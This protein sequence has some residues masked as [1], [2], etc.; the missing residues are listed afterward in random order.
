MS[1]SDRAAV[2]VLWQRC[3]EARGRLGVS[4]R[5]CIVGEVLRGYVGP[6]ASLSPLLDGA[7]AT[8]IVLV[9]GLL[10]ALCACCRCVGEECVKAV[11]RGRWSGV[12]S[13]GRAEPCVFAVFV[14]FG[15]NNT[16]GACL[17]V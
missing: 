9:A 3:A 12:C 17:A 1:D 11:V 7:P 4:S 8:F 14:G 16:K 2:S 13:R 10:F 15:D 5:V 6:V